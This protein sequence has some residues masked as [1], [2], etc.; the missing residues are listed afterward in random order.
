MNRWSKRFIALGVLCLFAAL[1]LTAYNCWSNVRAGEAAASALQQLKAVSHPA[2]QDPFSSE[3]SEGVPAF[4]L[5]PE[6]DMPTQEIDGQ[7][8]IG[9]LEIEALGLSLP[10]LSEWS[11]PGLRT[12]PCRY[13][14]SAYRNDL[15]I[16]AHNYTTHFGR[17]R[18]LSQGDAVTFTDVDG[19]VFCYQVAEV[20]TLPPYSVEEMTGGDWDLT[21]FTCTIGGQARVT[22]RCERVYQAQG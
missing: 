7:A 6:I 21:L 3:P 17:L 8:Y 22:V 1:C 18:E 5:H 11:Y 9:F 12:A 20:E 16:A 19:N 14:G 4:I 13:T 2:L 10:V 15:V